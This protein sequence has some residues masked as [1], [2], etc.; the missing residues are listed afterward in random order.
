MQPLSPRWTWPTLRRRS[1]TN[2]VNRF[3]LNMA[4]RMQALCAAIA[5]DYDG[6]ASRVGD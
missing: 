5:Q 4:K 6:D 2:R 1:A 3:L